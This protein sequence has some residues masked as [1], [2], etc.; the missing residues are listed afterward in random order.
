MNVLSWLLGPKIK[1]ITIR[2][3]DFSGTSFGDPEHCAI[4]KAV[5]RIYPDAEHISEH[6]YSLMFKW[7][8]WHKLQEIDHEIYE[9]EN[10]LTD[11]SIAMNRG[12]DQTVIRIIHVK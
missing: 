7:K 2:A 11:K 5:R 3:V 4:A 12:Y 6:V 8:P 1:S 10:F 9:H